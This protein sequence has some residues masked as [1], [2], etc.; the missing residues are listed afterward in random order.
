MSCVLR[1]ESGG[2]GSSGPASLASTGGGWHRAGLRS[3][4]GSWG[5]RGRRP[6]LGHEAEVSR[7]ISP[8]QAPRPAEAH[9]RP[10]PPPSLGP[11]SLTSGRSARSLE[12]RPGSPG[13]GS[14][15]LWPA[16]RSRRELPAAGR[17]Q[18]EPATPAAANTAALDPFSLRPGCRAALPDS[19]SPAHTAHLKTEIYNIDSAMSPQLFF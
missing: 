4:G 11:W 3:T 6:A 14:G 16:E 15:T 18:P 9:A 12:T 19:L 7:G 5:T 10:G 13:S 1:T 17:R 2:C 8:T